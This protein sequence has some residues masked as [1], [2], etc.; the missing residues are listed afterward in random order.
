MADFLYNPLS[1]DP[2][3]RKTYRIQVLS[4]VAKELYEVLL[5][6]KGQLCIENVTRRNEGQIDVQFSPLAEGT[7]FDLRRLIEKVVELVKVES[8]VHV[9]KPSIVDLSQLALPSSPLDEE[10]TDEEK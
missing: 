2:D 8:W 4:T 7:I 3:G 9:P 5:D 1:T 10:P 6:G